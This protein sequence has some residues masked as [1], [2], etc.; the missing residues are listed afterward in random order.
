MKT[1]ASPEAGTLHRPVKAAA[2]DEM[3]AVL[4]ALREGVIVAA[5][6]HQPGV[7]RFVVENKSALSRVADSWMRLVVT[8]RDCDAFRFEPRRRV[9]A[10]LDDPKHVGAR[11]LR[12]VSARRAGDMIEIE[13]ATAIESGLLRLS[14]AQFGL[15]LGG[16]RTVSA[17]ALLGDLSHATAA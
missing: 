15:M 16:G 6:R 12:I 9:D 11:Q 4:N 1:P 8:L 13:C 17:D 7:V 14:A 3:I 5:T 2:I 10:T